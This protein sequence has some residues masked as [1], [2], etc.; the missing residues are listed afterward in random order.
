MTLTA[1]DSLQTNNLSCLLACPPMSRSLV[2]AYMRL[3]LRLLLLLHLVTAYRHLV[4]AYTR[5]LL[6]LVPH[7]RNQLT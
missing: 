4:T 7:M 2:T 5:L 1:L 3:R 6:I